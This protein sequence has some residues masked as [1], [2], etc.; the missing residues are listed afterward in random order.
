MTTKAKWFELYVQAGFQPIAVFKEKKAPVGMGWNLN[1]TAEKWRPYF[2]IEDAYDMGI[3]LGDI[4]DV[5]GDTEEANDLL[6]QMTEYAPHPMFRSQKSTHHLFL[7][8]YPELTIKKFN[9]MEFRANRHQ[10]VV[11][12]ST[13]KSGAK[14][15]WLAGSKFRVPEMPQ[16]LMDYYELNNKCKTADRSKPGHTQIDCRICKEAYF[17]HKKRLILE[18]RAFKKLKLPWMC[19]GCREFD[20]RES[21]RSIRST[22]NHASNQKNRLIFPV[23]VSRI[24]L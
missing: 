22:L 16:E 5:E 4:I 24:A 8:P 21:C 19:H 20:I 23:K 13:H 2:E 14:Y 1:W 11:P 15:G 12:P 18:L 7:N 6:M 10:S 9:G 17:I 3:L